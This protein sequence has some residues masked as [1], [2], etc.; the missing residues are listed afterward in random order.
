LLARSTVTDLL[1]GTT[2]ARPCILTEVD[3]SLMEP[4]GESRTADPSPIRA[5]A[6]LKGEPD[7]EE[8]LCCDVQG[9]AMAA[10][11]PDA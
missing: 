8:L 10:S 2:S 4:R 6:L 7:S 9:L 1:T 3:E 5:V 11:P